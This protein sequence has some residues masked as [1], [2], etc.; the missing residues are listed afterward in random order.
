M[1]PNMTFWAPWIAPN[2][3][4]RSVK[5]TD[6]HKLLHF[7]DPEPKTDLTEDDGED[8]PF[9]EDYLDI[10]LCESTV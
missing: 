3:A 4:A 10:L 1:T 5:N 2:N 6:S 8:A 7:D 9:S